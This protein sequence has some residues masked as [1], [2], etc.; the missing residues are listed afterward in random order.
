MNSPKLV[1]SPLPKSPLQETRPEAPVLTDGVQV[2]PFDSSSVEKRYLLVRSDGR[3]WHISEYLAGVINAIDGKLDTEG[4]AVAVSAS[5][6]RP[7]G[8]ADIERVLSGFLSANGIVKRQTSSNQSMPQPE[9]IAPSPR[10]APSTTVRLRLIWGRPLGLAT[11]AMVW[12]FKSPLVWPLVCS[13]IGFQV[14]WSLSHLKTI[15]MAV[16]STWALDLVAILTFVLVSLMLHE[17]GHAAACR[18]FGAKAGE[19]GFAI[20]LV[21]PVFYCDVT[22][23][24]KLSRRERAALDLAGLYVQ[25]LFSALM[26]A[27]YIA[28]GRT[29]FLYTFLAISASYI[30]NLNPFLK[31][32]G[33]WFLSDMLGVANLSQRVGELLRGDRS[34]MRSLSPNMAALTYLYLVASIAYMA[35]FFYWAGSY[36]VALLRGGYVNSLRDLLLARSGDA[37]EILPALLT[38]LASTLVL[39]F[40][41]FLGWRTLRG[42]FAWMKDIAGILR[43]QRTASL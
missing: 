6:G 39:V 32:D 13:M 30:P 40:L 43:N 33:Y 18:A 36:A 2:L 10:R 11:S 1:E 22:D 35:G 23:A 31:M 26:L 15:S 21:F 8:T 41:P 29:L 28:S 19:I 42:C 25:C 20:Y 3:R 34:T 16:H 24:W 5:F 38:V 17:F 4:I 14:V 7:V 27:T 9:P 12:L 37:A